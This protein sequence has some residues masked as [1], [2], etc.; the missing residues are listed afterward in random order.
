MAVVFVG[1]YIIF[2]PEIRH[3]SKELYARTWEV[4]VTTSSMSTF[5]IIVWSMLLSFVYWCDRVYEFWRK[6]KKENQKDALLLAIKAN[7]RPRKLLIFLFVVLPT[8][9]IFAVRTIYQ[10]SEALHEAVAGLRLANQSLHQENERFKEGSLQRELHDANDKAQFETD[11]ARR[12]QE[13]YEAVS[14]GQL[15]DRVLDSEDL[16]RLRE[17]LKVATKDKQF[18]TVDI[19]CVGGDQ[20]KSDREACNLAWFYLYKTF[21]ESG[22]R[23]RWVKKAPKELES[24]MNVYGPVG[25]TIWAD[26]IQKGNFIMQSLMQSVNYDPQRSGYISVNQSDSPPPAYKGTLIWVGYKKLQ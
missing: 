6:L 20:P 14:K 16:R 22:W 10:D 23:A 18:A 3:A 11:S 19:G 13:A 17:A 24:K 8:F 25:I 5:G 15:P 12:W 21:K 26:N 4:L 2:T 7:I 1:L 9:G